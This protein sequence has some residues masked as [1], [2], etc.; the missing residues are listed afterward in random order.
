MLSW[1]LPMPYLGRRADSEMRRG[2]LPAFDV[3]LF[4]WRAGISSTFRIGININSAFI[5]F[6]GIDM[7]GDANGATSEQST[8]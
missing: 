8:L 6:S 3:W 1:K 2:L 5:L 7:R 4:E